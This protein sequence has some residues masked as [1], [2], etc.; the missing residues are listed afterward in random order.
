M[1]ARRDAEPV[2]LATAWQFY[3][4]AGTANTT[5]LSR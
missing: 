4:H 2:A 1:I 3:C 5:A